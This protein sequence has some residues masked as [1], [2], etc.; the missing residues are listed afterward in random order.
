MNSSENDGIREGDD[1]TGHAYKSGRITSEASGGDDTEGHA[2]R[3]GRVVPEEGDDVEGHARMRVSPPEEDDVEGH[4]RARV[5]PEE[6]DDDVEGHM[7]PYAGLGP[8]GHDNHVQG[9]PGDRPAT[10]GVRDI[11]DA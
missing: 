2:L 10:R 6:G 3:S 1:V 4:A 11:D 7:N 8:G 9:R 5:A